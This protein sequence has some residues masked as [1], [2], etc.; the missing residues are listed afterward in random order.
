MRSSPAAEET[1]ERD[2]RLSTEV[3]S[4]THREPRRGRRVARRRSQLAIDF[5]D[6]DR[7]RH[8][9]WLGHSTLPYA[10]SLIEREATPIHCE[11]TGP[12]GFS[13]SV[14]VLRNDAF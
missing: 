3:G 7:L 6:T 14:K 5:P 9:A 11:L 10:F 2:S 4:P 13:A 12:N 8:I 1:H